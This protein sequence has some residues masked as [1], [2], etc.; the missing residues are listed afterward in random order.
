MITAFG[1]WPATVQSPVTVS[2]VSRVRDAGGM[3]T[4]TPPGWPVDVPPPGV[5]GWAERAVDW[6]LDHCPPDYRGYDA[7]RR[8]PVALAW[9][10]GRHIDGQVTAMRE[11]YRQVRVELGA[12]VTS[13]ALSDIMGSLE[14]EGARL[15]AARRST[16]LVEGALRG[17]PYVPR[18]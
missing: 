13:E 2:G 11:A 17:K 4:A 3:T 18:M 15:V 16:G 14:A 7:F 10:T 9:I 6:L 5:E 8:H 1:P 12:A